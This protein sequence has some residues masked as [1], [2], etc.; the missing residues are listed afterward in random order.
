MA[1]DY[2][3]TR[4][5]AENCAQLHKA[6]VSVWQ[7]RQEFFPSATLQQVV[8]A[9]QVGLMI[10][11]DFFNLDE[12]DPKIFDPSLVVLEMWTVGGPSQTNE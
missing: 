5:N 11:M 4:L 10:H 1:G 7:L 6:G 12:L 9:I 2:V 8:V 3:F